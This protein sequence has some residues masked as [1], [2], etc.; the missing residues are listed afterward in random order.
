VS[1]R[2]IVP[3]LGAL[4]LSTAVSAIEVGDLT[5]G[6]FVD[7]VLKI[8]TSDGSGSTGFDDSIMDFSAD[9]ELQFGYNIGDA[10]SAQVDVQL[11]DGAATD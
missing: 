4:A 8:E 10:V 1:L 11:N 2:Q 6:G 7:T 5:I 3:T 9:A